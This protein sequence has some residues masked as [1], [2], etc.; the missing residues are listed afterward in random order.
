MLATI[1]FK[2]FVCLLPVCKIVVKIYTNLI[3][4]IV[5]IGV[6]FGLLHW[7]KEIYRMRVF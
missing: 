3:L 5:L 1:M 7:G 6:K 2:I 4:D